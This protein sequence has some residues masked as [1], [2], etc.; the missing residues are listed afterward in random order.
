MGA[1]SARSG[2]GHPPLQPHGV[3]PSCPR[4]S[5]DRRRS[6]QDASTGG[7]LRPVTWQALLER[8][9]GLATRAQLERAGLTRRGI[10]RLVR[11]AGLER[12]GGL[13]RDR[14]LPPRGSYLLSG[15][16]VDLGYLA[17]VRRAQLLRPGARAARS[18]AA[19]LWGMDMQV[20]PSAVELDVPAGSRAAPGLRPTRTSA[21]QLWTP[22]AGLAPLRVTPAVDTVL[23]CAADLP[24]AQAV[25]VTD[26]ALRRRRC[27]L[28]ALRARAAAGA[29]A[30]AARRVLRWVD[31]RSGSVL[32]SLL[33]VL[34]SEAGL[35]PEHTQHVLVD[36]VT[37]RA[38]RVDLAWPSARL[39]VEVDGRRWHDPADARDRD[40]RRDNTCAL[41]GWRVLRYTWADVVHD[42]ARVVREVRE[43]LAVAA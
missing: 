34:L 18:T 24:L 23:A 37:G 33:R 17:E 14:P 25:A 8:Q 29:A 9:Q 27:S 42:G 2:P 20:E 36:P 28:D 7:S 3:I 32:E 5:T 11:S 31:A 35:V 41:L 39:V 43:A 1:P 21:S 19:V 26:S 38:Q 16:A 4:L 13:Y 6:P 22:V 30:T 40:R 12:D 15:G 10:E